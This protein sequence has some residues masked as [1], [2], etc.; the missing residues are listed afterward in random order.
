MPFLD[1][2]FLGTG[3]SLGVPVIGCHC[4]VC[5]SSNPHNRRSRASVAL[6]FEEYTIVIDTSPEF[7][8]QALSH[9]IERVDAILFTHAHAD[10]I[11][12]FDDIRRFNQLQQE[13]IP[14]FGDPPTLEILRKVF[15]YAFDPEMPN[16]QLPQ[17]KAHHVD[18]PFQLF[19]RSIIPIQVLHGRLPIT[20]YRMGNLAYVTD[21]SAIP[22][23]SME[24]LRGLDVLILNAL[25]HAPHPSHFS[26]SQALEVIEE[27]Q[28]QRA[29]L[30]HISHDLEHGE[31]IDSLPEHIRPAYDGLRIRVDAGA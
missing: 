4:P 22:Q 1:I 11:F 23:D 28:P 5:R 26:L 12:G 14:V 18:G 20:A 10:H 29:Y 15:S 19:G 25:R 16:W 7:R 2:T 8:L 9:G 3:T 21:C 24:S 30:T 31:L 13:V 17:V 6:S 27:L